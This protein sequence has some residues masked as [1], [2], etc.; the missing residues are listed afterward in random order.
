VRLAD[1]D[2]HLPPELIAQNP[3]E[4]RDAA[5][6][7]VYNTADRSISHHHISD[8]PNLLP[9]HTTLVANRSRVRKGRL[10]AT[11]ANGQEVELLILEPATP[12]CFECMIRG[13]GIHDNEELQMR[14]GTILTVVAPHNEASFTT[15]IIDFGMSTEDAEA[16]IEEYGVTPLPPYITES[17]APDDRYQTV[18]AQEL[19][20]AAAPTAGLHITP[21]LMEEL[22]AKG[23]AWEEVI[24]HV[25]MGTFQPLR[26]EEITD[27]KLHH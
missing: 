27:N 1:I 22:I 7:L 23:H 5:R 9:V 10:Y 19:G 20:S 16:I 24:L 26:Q 12:G 15:Y 25:G 11:R 14:S 6:L 2:F 13:K 17:E 18:F 3:V 8:L 4:P 21:N